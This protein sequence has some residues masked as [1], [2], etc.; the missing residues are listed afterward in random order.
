MYVCKGTYRG[1]RTSSDAIR[2][3]SSIPTTN[4]L[5][6]GGGGQIFDLMGEIKKREN[7]GVRRGVREE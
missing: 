5:S 1:E 6:K 7:V 4:Y 2:S 3:L